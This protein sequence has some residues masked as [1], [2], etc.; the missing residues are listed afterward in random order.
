M[1]LLIAFAAVAA[2]SL[3]F[4]NVARAQAPESSASPPAAVEKANLH[5]YVVLLRENL[6][7]EKGEIL[8]AVMQFSPADANKFWPIYDEYNTELNKLNDRRLQNIKDYAASYSQMTDEKADHLTRQALDF[9]KQRT[10]LLAKYY[11]RVKS[12]LGATT[13]A[14]FLQ[15]ENQLLS[16]IDLQIDGNLPIVKH[17]S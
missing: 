3:G 7:Q 14:R 1:K 12:E 8:G 6:R 15:V 10:D 9:Q 17:G 11:E 5:E 13:A 16:L 2:A 4:A